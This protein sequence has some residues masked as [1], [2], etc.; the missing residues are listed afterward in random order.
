M[1]DED[2]D[3]PWHPIIEIKR[4]REYLNECYHDLFLRVLKP[5]RSWPTRP[6]QSARRNDRPTLGCRI[7]GNYGNLKPTAFSCRV[8][9]TF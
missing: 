2:Q 6:L 4:R 1:N 9:A 3:R 7:V 8:V 5:R